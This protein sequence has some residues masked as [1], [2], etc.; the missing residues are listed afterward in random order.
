MVE[1]ENRLIP[2]LN[3]SVTLW[4]RYVDDTFTFIKKGEVENVLSVLNSFHSNIKFTYEKEAGESIAF[5]D[6]KVLKKLDGSFDTD[7]YRKP[8]D[9][10]IYLNW[11]SFAPKAWKV[12]TLKGLIRRALVI[13]STKEFQERE[14]QL[15]KNVFVK[16]NGFPS[17]IVSKNI[18]EVRRKFSEKSVNTIAD[19]EGIVNS[20]Q[21]NLEITEIEANPFLCLPYKGKA[22]EDVLKSFK[23]SL[24]R[25]LPSKVKPRIVFNGKKLGSFFRIKDKVPFEH[26]SDC[27]Y[28]FKQDGRTDYVGETNVRFGSRTHEHCHTDKKSAVFKY[29]NDKNIEVSP[30]DFVILD[31][32]YKKKVDRK[33]AEALYI[34]DLKP[35]L[36][37]QVSSFKLSLFN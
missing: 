30:D 26:Q 22:G 24:S 19:I 21:N 27:V 11:S 23:K 28:A 18:E 4:Y 7:I 37:E 10:N 9:S 32:G 13:C 33:L 2:Q 17:K 36:N 12:G 25:C 15:L 29:K 34:K 14:I 20:V 31:K 3:D 8:T 6:V 1:L 35:H 5:L 16:Y